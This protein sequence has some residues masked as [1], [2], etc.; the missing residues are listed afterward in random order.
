MPHLRPHRI[1][2]LIALAQAVAAPVQASVDT[3][4]PADS[5]HV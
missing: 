3:R 4:A 2:L 5:A 1:A